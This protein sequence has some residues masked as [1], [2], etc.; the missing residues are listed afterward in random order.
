VFLLFAPHHPLLYYFPYPSSFSSHLFVA[1]CQD[2]SYQLE[3]ALHNAAKGEKSACRY[4]DEDD[5][6]TGDFGTFQTHVEGHHCMNWMD[7]GLCVYLDILNHKKKKMVDISNY[8]GSHMVH[9]SFSHG[10]GYHD[11][12]FHQNLAHIEICG[13]TMDHPYAT[14]YGG[15]AL[16]MSIDAVVEG[17]EDADEMDKAYAG[18]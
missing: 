1:T 10:H 16:Y 17:E 4:T 3:Q 15:P 11:N 9:A 6:S 7:E 8:L 5:D 2:L 18:N 12:S 14:S 13:S